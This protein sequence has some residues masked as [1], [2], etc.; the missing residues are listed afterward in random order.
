MRKSYVPKHSGI[1]PIQKMYHMWGADCKGAV[2]ICNK[3][4][5][6][7]THIQTLNFTLRTADMQEWT[8]TLVVFSPT[9]R[10]FSRKYS[11]PMFCGLAEK[12]KSRRKYCISHWSKKKHSGEGIP[13]T[14][15]FPGFRCC[16][17]MKTSLPR[18]INYYAK[19][20]AYSYIK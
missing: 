20:G 7:L 17:P 5:N 10:D 11:S 4:T 3:Q 8:V 16:R 2:F 15:Q 18:S 19:L 14:A 6:P 9:R 13:R 12:P 1:I